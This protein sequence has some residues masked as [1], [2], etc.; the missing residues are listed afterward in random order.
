MACGTISRCRTPCPGIAAGLTIDAPITLADAAPTVL[1]LA[2][3]PKDPGLAGRSLMPCLRRSTP[4]TWRDAVYTQTNGNEQ[5]GIQRSITT[6]GWK[7]VYNGFDED[8]LY[9]LDTDPHEQR[10]VAGKPEHAERIR[11]LCGRLWAFAGDHDDPCVNDYI[12]VGMAP[13]GPAEG[14]QPGVLA[15]G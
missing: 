5:Y 2:G 6:A 11:T 8:E 7:Y 15:N 10:N 1:E 12:L 4:A 13:Y 14:C 9:D 3:L